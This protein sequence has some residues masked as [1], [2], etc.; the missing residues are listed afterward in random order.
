MS[1]ISEVV[2]GLAPSGI[3]EFFDLVMGMDDVISLGVGEP[4]FDTPRHIRDAMIQSIESGYNN[5]T[6][7]QGMPELR[8]IISNFIEQRHG[9]RY[10]PDTEILITVG[11]SEAMDLAMRALIN[12][13]D[14]VI[15]P[16]P[17]YVSYAPTAKM[18]GAGEKWVSVFDRNNSSEHLHRIP[19]FSHSIIPPIQ[20]G[21]ATV[22]KS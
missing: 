5:Y 4:D 17:S 6:S 13:G 7:N 12:P 3:R 18:A 11:V 16:S 10:S 21:L 22:G 2:D 8:E 1:N 19:E 14:D 20:P 15:V 9:I